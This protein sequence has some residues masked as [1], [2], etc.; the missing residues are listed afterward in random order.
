MGYF[1]VCTDIYHRY[2][3]LTEMFADSCTTRGMNLYL[4]Q[5]QKC[6]IVLI[7]VADWNLARGI[8]IGYAIKCVGRNQTIHTIRPF[9]P[10]GL[11]GPERSF[12]PDRKYT[13]SK[14][15]LEYAPKSR[16]ACT[17]FQKPEGKTTVSVKAILALVSGFDI[18]A[19]YHYYSYGFT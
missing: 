19:N 7:L 10:N 2:Q 18:F 13:R 8:F 1:P 17:S 11:F 4:L 6:N 14:C 12:S 16:Q 9:F 3:I 5:F 15:T